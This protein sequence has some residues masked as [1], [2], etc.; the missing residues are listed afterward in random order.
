[1]KLFDKGKDLIFKITNLVLVLWLVGAMTGLWIKLT[2]VIYPQEMP[3][4]KNYKL[5]YC[6]YYSN[7]DG[8]VIPATKDNVS[9]NDDTCKSNYNLE[10]SNL[11]DSKYN[12]KKDIFMLLG[13][14]IIVGLAIY[15]L[16][17]KK[18]QE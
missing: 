16:N 6:S 7:T 4:Y 8:T 9:S 3:T 13:N 17:R 14:V 15:I 1:M 12:D 11:E 18:D 2:D 10:A 5:I